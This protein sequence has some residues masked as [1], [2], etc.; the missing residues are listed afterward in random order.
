MRP[1]EILPKPSRTT[2]HQ[3]NEARCT[4]CSTEPRKEN[5]QLNVVCEGPSNQSVSTDRGQIDDY[6]T[7]T[8]LQKRLLTVLV[9]IGAITS[10]LTATI[11]FPLLPLLENHFRTDTQAINLTLTVYII[12][13]AVSP[14]IFGPW[15]D[16]LGRRPVY[17]LTIFLYCIGNLGLA[18]NKSSYVALIILRAVQSMGASAAYAISYGVVADV[19]RPSERGRMLGPVNMALNLGTC[20]GPVVGGWVAYKSKGYEWCFWALVILGLVLFTGVALFLPETARSLVGNGSGRQDSPRYQSVW[21]LCQHNLRRNLSYLRSNNELE[22]VTR[23]STGLLVTVMAKNLLQC[24]RI[25]LH[26][27]AALSLWMHGS[28]YVV[29]YSLV[30]TAPSIYKNIYH[31]NELYIG[32]TYLARGLGIVIGSYCNG[33]AMDYNYKS[34]ARKVGLS[35]ESPTC[36]E[37]RQF[38]FERAR[39]RGSF[40]LLTVS[41]TA[42]V[43]YGWSVNEHVHM[44]APLMLQFIL[45]MLG[46]CFYTI[47]ITLLV[48]GFSH[49]PSTA[50]ATASVARCAMAASAVALLQPL[51][52]AAGYGWYF[53]IL[54]IWSGGCGAIAVFLVRRKGMEWRLGRTPDANSS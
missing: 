38:P 13:Q 46:T 37:L 30:A 44:A 11:Y 18:L 16:S 17:L 29:D 39:S 28:F 15:S 9:G 7:F 54:G 53:S 49:S 41:T 20:I 12:F 14:A 48:D 8:R 6:T 52:G 3:E 27:D 36:H 21:T 31:L 50:A 40:W 4:T 26:R 51:I 33:K 47:Y 2:E 19:C 1:S 34:V 32:L 43:A 42:L 23:Q 35:L 22:N 10:P 25:A 24:F 45:G 5:V